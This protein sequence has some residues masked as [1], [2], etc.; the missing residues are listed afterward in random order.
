[1]EL[2]PCLA[3]ASNE[4]NS[5]NAVESARVPAVAWAPRWALSGGRLLLLASVCSAGILAT[6]PADAQSVEEMRAQLQAMQRRIAQ[7]EAAERRAAQSRAEV[8]R[9][10]A[11]AQTAQQQAEAARAQTEQVRLQTVQVQ[12]EARQQAAN[13]LRG[14]MPN[15]IRIPGTNTSVRLYGF[16]KMS[17]TGDLGPR[18]RSDV[19][20]A[21]S[22]PLSRG[23]N[24]AR[25][26]G[27]FN[28]TA[29]R[30]R[31]DIET[32]TFVSESFGSVRTLVEFDFA[33]QTNDL[34]T[35]ATSNAYTPRLRLAYGEFGKLD[36]W[37]TVL[38]GQAASLYNLGTPIQWLSD[39]TALGTSA[40]RQAQIRY[41]KR[42]GGHF[43]AS[44]ALENSYSDIT[45]AT[46]T[47]Y[48]DN[49]G[50]AGFGVNNVPDLTFRG[51]W[52]D[53]WGFLALRGMVRQIRI[54]NNGATVPGQRYSSSTT[55]YGIGLTGAV[56][57][58]DK[59]LVLAGAADF[60]DGLG[61]YLDSTSSGVGAVT[62]FGANG[63]T[64]NAQIDTVQVASAYVGAKYFFTPTL[65]SNVSLHG[66]HLNYP[67]YV[68]QFQ[69]C[70]GGAAGSVCNALNRD[71]WVT[72]ANL[73]WS[74]ARMID[75]GIEYQH[76]E[77]TLENRNRDS[78]RGGKADRIQGSVIV[79]F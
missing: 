1:M 54:E 16:A 26:E 50:G 77:R 73:I 51:M 69:G 68:A 7:I 4:R 41:S 34:T 63:R 56:N 75:V 18:N 14:S 25:S 79:R 76:V 61:R 47:S 72:A 65:R 35:Q 21:Q 55:G 28:A 22:I 30:S 23:A 33:G 24:G 17:M 59:R 40:T 70:G 45:S 3:A 53:T 2:T 67:S 44:V 20:T 11:A 57:L 8:Q 10:A 74:P 38:A 9:A 19:I 48:P 37:G 36:G 49:N 5:T 58:L 12:T 43:T 29:R 27:G 46:G 42:F 52:E 64:S 31:V 32:D 71:I 6:N 39:W 15:S 60:G 62:D 13:D 78:V 66:A